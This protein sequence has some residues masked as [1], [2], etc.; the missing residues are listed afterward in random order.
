MAEQALKIGPLE[1][2]NG[3]IRQAKNKP[4]FSLF[5]KGWYLT[6]CKTWKA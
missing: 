4:V 6:L 5:T 3:A 2:K 1:L